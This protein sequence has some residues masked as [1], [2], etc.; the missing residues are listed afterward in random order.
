MQFAS[1]YCGL[2][3]P[4]R[5]DIEYTNDANHVAQI[6][7]SHYFTKVYIY[8]CSYCNSRLQKE[9]QKEGISV[10]RRNYNNLV[11]F[12]NN[13]YL[14]DNGSFK[15][16]CDNESLTYEIWYPDIIYYYT[17]KKGTVIEEEMFLKSIKHGSIIFVRRNKDYLISLRDKLLD[18]SCSL[19]KIKGG[20][21]DSEKNLYDY[22][23]VNTASLTKPATN[24]TKN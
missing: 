9:L 23:I 11:F 8:N 12:I 15:V 5:T 22:Y 18:Y 16:T 24:S 17:N 7:K 4:T 14:I 20:I 3:K 21:Y 1:L 2:C 6:I 19:E 10:T 13:K